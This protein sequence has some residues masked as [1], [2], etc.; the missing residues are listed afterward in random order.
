MVLHRSTSEVDSGVSK[1]KLV[2]GIT[3][4]RDLRRPG[5]IHVAFLS[6]FEVA[7]LHSARMHL[8]QKRHMVLRDRLGRTHTVDGIPVWSMHLSISTCTCTFL[9][10]ATA[11][12]CSGMYA[13]HAT[14][15]IE[16]VCAPIDEYN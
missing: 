15:P 13:P 11:N 5:N 16:R 6:C 2:V 8:T 9:P 7:H 14:K 1:K 12:H 3:K 4:Y 10:R